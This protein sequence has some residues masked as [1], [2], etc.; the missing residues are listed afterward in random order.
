MFPVWRARQDPILGLSAS[1]AG[2]PPQNAFVAPKL[3]PHEDRG[4]S[5]NIE[6]DG[7]PRPKILAFYFLTLHIID[8]VP[9]RS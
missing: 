4:P 3:S 5:V 8:C 1:V 7:R 6:K 9:A 2:A